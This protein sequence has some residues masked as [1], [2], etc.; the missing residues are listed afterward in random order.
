MARDINLDEYIQKYGV[1]ADQL[2]GIRKES[3]GY[4]ELIK[5]Y[6]LSK[7]LPRSS[8]GNY[9][10]YIRKSENEELN[11]EKLLPLIKDWWTF[12]HPNVVIEGGCPWVKTKEYLDLDE[13]EKA[14]FNME[15]IP[16]D[17]VKIIDSCRTKTTTTALCYTRKD[18][19]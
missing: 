17:L 5:E 16:E 1:L 19:T 12:H 6:L 14:L 4:K 2:K 15:T 8:S 11:T 18:K 13:M 7:N 3:D 10:V 9:E